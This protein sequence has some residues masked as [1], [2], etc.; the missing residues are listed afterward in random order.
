MLKSATSE[1]RSPVGQHPNE[2]LRVFTGPDSLVPA[3][4]PSGWP[5]SVTGAHDLVKLFVCEGDLVRRPVCAERWFEI[6]RNRAL[7]QPFPVH[8][9]PEERPDRAQAFSF[10]P[11]AQRR[12]CIKHIDVRRCE[13]VEHDVAAALRELA[14]LLR[15]CPILA[16]R[17]RGNLGP[18]R[19]A[20]KAAVASD[21]VMR[22]ADNG[23]PDSSAAATC[24]GGLARPSHDWVTSKSATTDFASAHAVRSVF[25]RLNF[26]PR[27]PGGVY[28][29]EAILPRPT[30]LGRP[31]R[32]FHGESAHLGN[33]NRDGDRG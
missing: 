19:T 33:A 12:S 16:Q 18:S 28:R 26:P 29:A 10:R 31:H 22:D 20:R 5:Q 30:D 21:S 11:H 7:R 8:A 1:I 25:L 15:E 32:S 4:G 23:A 13:L 9:E 17:S 14:Q 6:A 27:G 2:V 3:V 24:G